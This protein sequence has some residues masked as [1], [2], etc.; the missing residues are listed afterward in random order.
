MLKVDTPVRAERRRGF[1]AGRFRRLPAYCR[2][3]RGCTDSRSASTFR[4]GSCAGSGP[5]RRSRSGSTAIIRGAHVFPMFEIELHCLA[6]R[7]SRAGRRADMVNPDIAGDESKPSFLTT[8][9]WSASSRSPAG[10]AGPRRPC[11]DAGPESRPLSSCRGIPAARRPSPRRCRT[12]RAGIRGD[13]SKNTAR[14]RFY[15]KRDAGNRCRRSGG[16]DGGMSPASPC[17]ARA[18][19]GSAQA[20]VDVEPVMVGPHEAEF[21]LVDVRGSQEAVIQAF[22]RNGPSS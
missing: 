2:R 5:S 14:R 20:R 18:A 9:G 19:G 17:R 21:E 8:F 12:R 4:S 15:S 1:H 6:V 3:G 13:R 16:R 7:D 10:P 11:S 22:S